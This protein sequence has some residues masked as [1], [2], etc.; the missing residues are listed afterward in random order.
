MKAEPNMEAILTTWQELWKRLRLRMALKPK[1]SIE[2][3]R[4]QIQGMNEARK[5]LYLRKLRR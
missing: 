5:K 2:K 1:P 4:E 3:V